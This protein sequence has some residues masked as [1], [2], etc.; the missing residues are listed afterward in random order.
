MSNFMRKGRGERVEREKGM[1]TVNDGV[2]NNVPKYKVQRMYIKNRGEPDKGTERERG[3][4][5]KDEKNRTEVTL[6]RLFS[7]K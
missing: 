4:E 2:N 1:R 5:R 6:Q 7:L 3:K